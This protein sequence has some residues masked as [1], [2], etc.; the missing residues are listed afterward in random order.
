MSSRK[1][2]FTKLKRT[3]SRLNNLRTK[4]K[5]K[6]IGKFKKNENRVNKKHDRKENEQ[7]RMNK[8]HDRKE[9][10][11]R[12]NKR[13]ENENRMNKKKENESKF[14][15][16]KEKVIPAENR[17]KPTS[18]EFDKNSPSTLKKR[19]KAKEKIEPL[20]RLKEI[21]YQMKNF[22]QQ[23][24]E[25]EDYSQVEGSNGSE[26]VAEDYS[27]VEGSNGSEEEHGI[28]E[29]EHRIHKEKHGISEK[30]HK[31][32]KE[33]HKISENSQS[34]N[35][36]DL[37]SDVKYDF[38][39]D[40]QALDDEISFLGYLINIPEHD[41]SLIIFL[42][43][44]IS[45]FI[46]KKSVP[47]KKRVIFVNI[48]FKLLDILEIK[49]S[50]LNLKIC[51]ILIHLPI[52]IPLYLQLVK[53]YK[54]AYNLENK[55]I[56]T[57]QKRINYEKIKIPSNLLKSVQLKEFILEESLALLFTNLNIISNSMGFPEVAEPIIKSLKDGSEKGSLSASELSAS[58]K[59]SLTSDLDLKDFLTRLE[60]QIDLIKSKR[61]GLTPEC[62]QDMVDFE[63]VTGK[64]ID[65]AE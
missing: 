6:T 12:M 26:V 14:N 49:R 18:H 48:C 44:K 61:A 20:S 60:K 33:E 45:Q 1:K 29:K 51:Y 25:S 46:I 58:E 53:I 8:R 52:F 34:K 11:N 27:Q 55:E 5:N 47:S 36:E 4:E 7:N 64:M 31:I 50:I 65:Q 19:N 62:H 17:H 57:N 22:D 9:N 42:I 10:E 59:G 63:K 23:V 32:H 15:K 2:S 21:F 40:A 28:S 3:N 38:L 24:E 37:K 30:E 13:K 35:H 16:R 39:N 56:I 54:F 43:E 41:K